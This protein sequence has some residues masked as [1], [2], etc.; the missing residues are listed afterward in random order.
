MSRRARR[1]PRMSMSGYR[2]QKTIYNRLALPL[3]YAAVR[4]A[5]PFHRKL[6]ETTRGRVGVLDRWT[7]GAQR[8]GGRPVWFHVASV[9]EYEQA[10]PIITK[11]SVARP[12]I[13]VAISVTSPSGYRYITRKES[14]G[15]SGNLQFMDYLPFD[16]SGDAR[17]CLAALSPRLLVFVKFDLWPNLVWEADERG[18]PVVLVDATLSE[19]SKRYSAVGRKFYRAVYASLRKILAIS[20]ADAG[21]F[22]EC[23]PGHPCV[24]VAGD[25]RFDRVMERRQNGRG[26]MGRLSKDGRLTVVAGST[27]PR[28]EEHLLGA[29]SGLAKN[30]PRVR[31][32][33]A[34]HEPTPERVS[35]ILAWAAG[36]D[37]GAATLSSHGRTGGSAGEQVIVVDSVGVLAEIYECGDVAYVGGSFSTGVHNVMEPAVMGVPVLF[38]PVHRNSFEA[39]ELLRCGA[40]AEVRNAEEMSGALDSLIADQSKRSG[41]GERARSYVE[42]QL[43]ATERCFDAIREYL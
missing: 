36:N 39:M 17:F 7:A 16:F 33:I 9:G 41:M 40:A 30:H 10:R 11:L 29:L 13:P 34:P 28:D 25:T 8:L 4:A 38:G 43:G 22:L 12:D 21:R 3:A 26:T 35:G 14:I 1:T 37:L 18:T 20:D 15:A 2:A 19:T 6:R 31:F 42:S 24:V 23:A 27:W 32:V 5:A